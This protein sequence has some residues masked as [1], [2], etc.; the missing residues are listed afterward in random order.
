MMPAPASPHGQT[1]FNGSPSPTIGVEA[2]LFLVDPNTY[3]LVDGAPAVLSRFDSDPH[4]KAE[5]LESMIEVNT[6]ICDNVSA[7]RADLQARIGAVAKVTA[8]QHLGL[9]SMGTHPFG[10]WSDASVTRSDRYQGFLERMQ[11]PVR[12][13]LIS[14]LHVHIGVPDGERAIAVMNGLLRYIPHFIGLSANSPFWDGELTGLASTRMKVFEGMPTGGLPPRLTDYNQ[15]R[16]LVRTLKGAGAID[17]VSEVWWDIR[18]HPGFGTVEIRL[19]D[20][21]PSIGEMV[22]LAALSQ[23]LV[24]SLLEDYETAQQLP[25]LPEWVVRENKW[26][27]V[28]YGLGA[29]II[30]DDEGTRQPL[31]EAVTELLARLEPV[32]QRLGCVAEL[33]LLQEVVTAGAPGERG[34]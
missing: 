11:F 19:M 28:R 30:I 13:L 25:L 2:E 16:Q 12:R 18:P 34:R 29:E 9:V 24:V 26:R 3:D 23:S 17:S 31:K 10:R 20:A 1:R 8:E 14:G 4:V 33:T 5:L 7:V 22:S 27:A 15:F 32:A 6:S 21:V